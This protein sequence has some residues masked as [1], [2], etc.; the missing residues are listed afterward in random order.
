MPDSIPEVPVEVEETFTPEESEDFRVLLNIGIV[1][2]SLN[3]LGHPYV[4]RTLTSN[5]EICVGM[6]IKSFIGTNSYDRAYKTAIVAASMRELDGK[7]LYS[8]ILAQEEPLEIL[9][10]K[11][12]AVLAYSPLLVDAWYNEFILLEKPLALLASRLG[13]TSS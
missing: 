10:K 13:K 2:K 11:F 9:K 1:S 4:L 7:P 8:S 12:D 3:L 5:E 6:L